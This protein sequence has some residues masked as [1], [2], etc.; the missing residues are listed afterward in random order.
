MA[1]DALN[2]KFNEREAQK[3]REFQTAEREASQ[4]FNLDMWNMNNEYNSFSAQAERAREAGFSPESILGNQSSSQP[5][6]TTPQAGAQASFTSQMSPV[7]SGLV[8][9]MSEIDLINAEKDKVKSETKGQNL[10]NDFFEKSQTDRLKQI[11]HSTRSM[12]L[13]NLLKSKEFEKLDIDIKTAQESFNWLARFNQAQYDTMMVNLNVLRSD[14]I[15]NMQNYENMQK[16][17]ALIDEKIQ[18]ENLV[19]EGQR[20]DNQA[21]RYSNVELKYRA[22]FAKSTGLPIDTPPFEFQYKLWKDGLMPSYCDEVIKPMN[23]AT[24]KPNDWYVT[25]SQ[26]KS[27]Q[28]DYGG[29]LTV[30]GVDVGGFDNKDH[31][32]SSYSRTFDSRKA[33]TSPHSR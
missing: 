23:E 2:R 22:E 4:Q 17:G 18:T 3:N 30:F 25:E 10:E 29:E 32:S 7:L 24:F 14:F 12:E 9:Q 5:V 11:Q 1:N 19:Q 20:L 6:T 15:L 16:E 33:H 21:Q 26:Y 8:K 27:E 13:D 31:S 28:S